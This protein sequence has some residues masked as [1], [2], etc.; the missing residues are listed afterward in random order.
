LSRRERRGN[1]PLSEGERQERRFL[2]WEKLL[3]MGFL[4]NKREKTSWLAD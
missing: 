2:A 3:D 1:A 4:R